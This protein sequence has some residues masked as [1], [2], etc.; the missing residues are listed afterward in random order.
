MPPDGGATYCSGAGKILI[1]SK[2]CA[3]GTANTPLA[4]AWWA[5]SNVKRDM[6]R[7]FSFETNNSPHGASARPAGLESPFPVIVPFD[8]ALPWASIKKR[9]TVFVSKLP[10]RSSPQAV[11][12]MLSG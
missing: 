5:E 3:E 9:E 7:T 12:T 1:L 2:S 11:T 4:I 10:T 8:V 6:V